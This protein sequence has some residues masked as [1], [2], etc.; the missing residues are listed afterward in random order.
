MESTMANIGFTAHVRYHSRSTDYISVNSSNRM[1]FVKEM[2]SFLWGTNSGFKRYLHASEASNGNT[3][4]LIS[5]RTGLQQDIISRPIIKAN[6]SV[7]NTLTSAED[8]TVSD[9]GTHVYGVF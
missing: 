2:N 5:E 7:I 6:Y 1:V 3:S 8:F 9:Y 4:P